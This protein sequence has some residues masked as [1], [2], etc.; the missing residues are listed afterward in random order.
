MKNVKS[1]GFERLTEIGDVLD[2]LSNLSIES[3][4][5]EPISVWNALGRVVGESVRSKSAIPPF[6]R[7]AMD[8]YAVK[9]KDTSGSSFSDPTFLQLLARRIHAGTQPTKPLEKG[10][11]VQINTGARLPKGSNAVVRIENAEKEGDYVK[12]Y[13]SVYPGKDVSKKG[14]DVMEDELV[15]QKGER[16]TPFHL[17]M[18]TALQQFK[19]RVRAQPR[20]GFFACGDELIDPKTFTDHSSFTSKGKLIES[21]R[22]MLEGLISNLGAAPIDLGI[23]KDKVSAIQ[24]IIKRGIQRTNLLL[25]IGG[26]S[27]GTKDLLPNAIA[28]I[29]N[30]KVLVHGINAMPGKPLLL[31]K[32]ASKPVISLPGYPVSTAVDFL[33]FVKPLIKR[34]LAQEEGE[35]QWGISALLTRK[36]ASK[37]GRIHFVRV[38]LRREGGKIYAEPVRIK[39]AGVLKSLVKAD[40]FLIVPTNKEGFEKGAHV[41][42]VRFNDFSGEYFLSKD[43]REKRK[44]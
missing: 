2:I 14:E 8:G 40:G 32:I 44:K 42:I 30:S 11:A 12:I 24:D 18:L 34:L 31:S 20:I 43:K 5:T 4:E 13:D 10:E 28:H 26:T 17:S 7:A 15:I 1:T 16:L 37:P 41:N 21:N 33:L 23:V 6:N 35:Y 22:I 27:T 38:K 39:G 25:S 19:I 3:M 29:K 36:V 9:A